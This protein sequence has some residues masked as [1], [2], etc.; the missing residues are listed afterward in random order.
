MDRKGVLRVEKKVEHQCPKCGTIMRKLELLPSEMSEKRP[1]VYDLGRGYSGASGT[2]DPEKSPKTMVSSST[3]DG[4]SV[5]TVTTIP[6][7]SMADS[8]YS[9]DTPE[10]VALVPY[11][12]TNPGCRNRMS[13]RR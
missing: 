7:P 11:E 13:F 3:I 8:P 10:E 12:C 5:V 9:S 6:L 2:G 4:S 1:Q